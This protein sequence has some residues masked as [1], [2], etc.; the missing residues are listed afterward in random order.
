MADLKKSLRNCLRAGIPIFLLA[1]WWVIVSCWQV[2]FA[3]QNGGVLDETELKI[4]QYFN[5]I[6]S[7]SVFFLTL[8]TIVVFAVSISIV[9]RLV[10]Y[11]WHRRFRR[12]QTDDLLF[13]I[14]RCTR[15][16][17]MLECYRRV[18]INFSQE[19]FTISPNLWSNCSLDC[20]A[21]VSSTLL[22]TYFES[23]ERQMQIGGVCLYS[24]FADHLLDVLPREL[25]KRFLEA[26]AAE[27]E[28]LVNRLGAAVNRQQLMRQ[29]LAIQKQ[30][31]QLDEEEEGHRNQV[32]ERITHQMEYFQYLMSGGSVVRKWLQELLKKVR[33]AAA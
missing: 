19:S 13:E 6:S 23:I 28:Y 18:G 33:P 29:I 3:L 2:Y 16:K 22:D 30:I 5:L 25:I 8:T 21:T 15:G 27:K 31:E 7:N 20:I 26:V 11:Y 1:V 10:H 4:S 14:K 17:E 24:V 12:N 32:Q 9:F